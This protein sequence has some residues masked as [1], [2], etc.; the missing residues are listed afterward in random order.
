MHPNVTLYSADS[1]CVPAGAACS[2][3]WDWNCNG[4]EEKRWNG[5]R[6]ECPEPGMIGL[7]GGGWVGSNPACG[8][9]G[10]WQ[11]CEYG[12]DTDPFDFGAKA[13]PVIIGE[14]CRTVQTS[15]RQECR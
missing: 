7:R 3:S 12:A 9:T 6:C 10:T 2:F 13:G 11:T 1:Y 5:S 8:A 15:R 4:V 14:Q